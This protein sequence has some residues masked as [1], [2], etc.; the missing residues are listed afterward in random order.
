MYPPDWRTVS[1]GV[2]PPGPRRSDGVGAGRGRARPGRGRSADELARR[3][4]RHTERKEA[5]ETLRRSEEALRR[6]E[7]RYQLGAKA[8]GEAIWD[9]DL[10]TGKQEWAGATEALFGY[11]AHASNEGEWWEERVHPDD[12]N[13]VL[14]SLEAIYAAGG[15]S[16]SQEYRFRRADG[17]YVI[18][19][20]RACIV[21]DEESVPRRMVGS[22][23]DVT[24]RRRWERTLR[25]IEKRFHTTFEAS[26]VGMAHVALDGRWL[27]VNDKLCEISGYEREELLGMS[28]LDLTPKEDLEASRERMGSLIKGDLGPYT[29]QRRYVRKDGS[30]VW[31]ELSVSLEREAS[32]EPD[33]LFCVAED[34]TARKIQELVP[35]PLTFRELEVLRL[36]V[37]GR[38]N[39]C[40]ARGLSHSSSKMSGAVPARKEFSMSLVS[41]DD[42]DKKSYLTPTLTVLALLAFIARL[43]SAPDWIFLVLLLAAAPVVVWLVWNLTKDRRDQRNLLYSTLFL[44]FLSDWIAGGLNA[45]P[46]VDMLLIA[47]WVVVLPW[48]VWT[49][50]K[51]R[52]GADAS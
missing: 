33:Y 28:L 1:H 13:R 45:P 35:D 7:E 27:R 20:D 39:R 47:A 25:E 51:E 10:T 50:L 2:P 29:M 15:K 21:R 18:V 49:V 5:E 32:G 40:V 52:R 38:T 6:S 9:N 30:R 8:T 36:V 12:R 11:P 34:I 26:A 22:M 14:Y 23:V 43:M 19:V 24:E 48:I 3:E 46:W 17:E 4:A 41:R 44:L 42:H 31:V 37:A 16:W